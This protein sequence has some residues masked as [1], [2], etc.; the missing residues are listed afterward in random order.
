M[1][2]EY[3]LLHAIV[4]HESN[5]LTFIYSIFERDAANELIESETIMTLSSVWR[6]HRSNCSLVPTLKR[7]LFSLSYK[8]SSYFFREVRCFF[9]E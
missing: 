7:L 6:S 3:R 1:T 2:T 8:D 5:V 9:R 4:N